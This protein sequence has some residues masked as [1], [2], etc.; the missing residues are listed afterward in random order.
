MPT[1]AIRAPTYEPRAARDTASSAASARVQAVTPEPQL[2]TSRVR[3]PTRYDSSAANS[4]GE[5]MRPWA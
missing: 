5:R 2:K 4:S 1:R 3:S